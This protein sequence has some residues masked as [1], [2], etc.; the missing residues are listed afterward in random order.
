MGARRDGREAA[1]QFLYQIDIHRPGNMDEA[2]NA[3]WKQNEEPQ[4][5]RDFADNLLRGA[6]EKLPEI[7]AKI[8]A[9]ADNWDFERLAVVD[10]NILRLAVYE[11]LFRPEIPPVV[12]IN[13]AIEIAKKFST[14]E[15][16]KFV[17][18]LLDRVK[19]ELLRPSRQAAG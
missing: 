19:K 11:M 8:R 14:A 10:R 18:G 5:V 7:D 6:L 2:L 16:G 1:I 12:S 13:E 17:N 4:N 3:F 9:L 15:S